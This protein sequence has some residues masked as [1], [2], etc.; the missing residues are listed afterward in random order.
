MTLQILHGCTDNPMFLNIKSMYDLQK[1][2]YYIDNLPEPSPDFFFDTTHT[3]CSE[4]PG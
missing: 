3:D 1:D 2:Y 4:L